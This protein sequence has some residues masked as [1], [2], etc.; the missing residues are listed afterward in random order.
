HGHDRGTRLRRGGGGREDRRDVSLA[1]DAQQQ[2]VESGHF[3]GAGGRARR[4]SGRREHL[5]IPRGRRVRVIA[6]LAVRG[7]HRMHP[8]LLHRNVVQQ[9]LSRLLL[10]TFVVVGRE[11]AFVAPEDVQLRPIHGVLGGAA[12]YLFEYGDAGAPT[13]Q[14]DRGRPLAGLNVGQRRHQSGG[15]GRGEHFRVGVDDDS[16]IHA[17]AYASGSFVA[18]DSAAG[19]WPFAAAA[20]PRLLL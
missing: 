6:E 3:D 16:G 1:T 15:G 5:G 20:P 8:A 4:S 12:T 10:V 9:R 17:H 14:D 2:D 7:G 18:V 11:E 19:S 13:G